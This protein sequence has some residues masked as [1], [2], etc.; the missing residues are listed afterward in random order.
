LKGYDQTTNLILSDCQERIIAPNEPPEII[1][2]G[3][4]IVRGLSVAVIGQ[5]DDDVAK[6]IDWTK[7]SRDRHNVD[8]HNFN[9]VR[10]AKLVSTK[11]AY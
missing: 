4:Y 3:L 2:L 1:D 7:V 6:D 5:V 8:R 11:H 9:Q 10:G